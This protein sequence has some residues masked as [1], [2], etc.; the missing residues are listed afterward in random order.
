LD[1]WVLTNR[2]NRNN[3]DDKK[4]LKFHESFVEGL[5]KGQGFRNVHIEDLMKTKANDS[6]IL[7]A[8]DLLRINERLEEKFTETQSDD[9]F[10]IRIFGPG[11]APHD[12]IDAK[13][14]FV[15]WMQVTPEQIIESCNCFSLFT[16]DRTWNED[17]VWSTQTILNSIEDDNLKSKVWARL[18]RYDR[19]D[20]IGPLTLYLTLKEIAHCDQTTIDNLAS[21]LERV[22]LENFPNESTDDHGSVWL[23]MTTFLKPFNKVP[24]NAKTMLL[25][26]YSK[27]TVSLFRYHF[28]TLAS[29]QDPR[30]NTIESIINEGQAYERKLKDIGKW[31]P[32]KKQNSVF[33][34]KGSEKVEVDGAKKPQANGNDNKDKKLTHDKAGNPIDRHPPKANE[35]H[36]RLNALTKKTELWC[37]NPKCS[38]WGNHL[39][40]DHAEWKKKFREA[41]KKKQ[42]K[43]S[44]DKD[45]GLES[46]AQSGGA[47][48][49]PRSNFV[50]TVGNGFAGP[51]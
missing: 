36:E 13:S 50:G 42:A 44:D 9:V 32:T 3:F 19:I 31:N 39:T 16:S 51:F 27:C 20:R 25:E 35:S 17:L 14:L 43:K 10:K 47:L 5:P 38:R 24:V 18:E 15:D 37:G 8:I 45:K 2:A 23:K 30:L 7:A 22:K 34:S 46:T 28:N 26:Q 33:L 1:G 6:A 49:I 41:M 48:T 29:M 11:G 40:K 12:I 21:S 4:K